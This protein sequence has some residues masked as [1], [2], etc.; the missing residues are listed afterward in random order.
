MAASDLVLADPGTTFA[1]PEV[2]LGLVPATVAPFVLQRIGTMYARQI[3]F[4]GMQ[5]DASGALDMGLVDR[6]VAEKDA[7]DVIEELVAGFIQ[8][9]PVAV[10]LTKNMINGM[11]SSYIHED[12]R[13]RAIASLSFTLSQSV[14]EMMLSA[15]A[16]H[17]GRRTLEFRF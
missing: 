16:M 9:S 7:G 3:M 6:M 15:A 1:F 17:E 2:N 14:T 12:T 10:R 4:T 8:A 11:G 5:M 13:K